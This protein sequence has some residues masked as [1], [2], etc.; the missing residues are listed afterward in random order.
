MGKLKAWAEE[1]S[2]TNDFTQGNRFS[3]DIWDGTIKRYKLYDE[4]LSGV[5]CFSNFV[6]A[7]AAAVR[8]LT[9]QYEQ[10]ENKLRDLEEL[11]VTE[12]V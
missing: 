4:E 8:I 5:R 7:K 2:V 11:K 6:D 1:N 9:R 3:V 10:L 12:V